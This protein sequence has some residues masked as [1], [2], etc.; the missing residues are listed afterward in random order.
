MALERGT[1][2]AA[3]DEKN[4]EFSDMSRRF[5]FAVALNLER[6]L[7]LQKARRAAHPPLFAPPAIKP[8]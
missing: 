3:D 5:W 6:V 1:P 8:R 7:T 4:P 2:S